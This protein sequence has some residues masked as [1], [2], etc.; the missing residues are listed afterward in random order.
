VLV[1]GEKLRHDRGGVVAGR[2]VVLVNSRFDSN[3]GSFVAN[4]G[5]FDE[6][7]HDAGRDGLN[8]TLEGNCS[9]TRAP[10]TTVPLLTAVLSDSERRAE[11]WVSH[12]EGERVGLGS[13][14][15]VE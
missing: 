14:R 7:I 1:L 11:S 4:N 2:R 12:P 9:P 15:R 6:H 3:N 13:L 8:V 5:E 10:G